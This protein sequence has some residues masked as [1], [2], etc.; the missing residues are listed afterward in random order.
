[1]NK[2]LHIILLVICCA[3]LVACNPTL[4]N[5]QPQKTNPSNTTGPTPILSDKTPD[6]I[7]NVNGDTPTIEPTRDRTERITITIM[8]EKINPADLHNSTPITGEVPEEILGKIIEDL[9]QRTDVDQQNIQIIRA[10]A[11]TWSD[12]SLGCPKP[13]EMYTAALVDGYWV[14]LQLD[15]KNYDYRVS[16]SGYFKLCEGGGILPIFPPTE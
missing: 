5:D 7:P 4:E 10:E 12:G 15:G 13:G 16:N 3:I 9:I 6:N 14:V 2:S 1:M 8:P 11:V